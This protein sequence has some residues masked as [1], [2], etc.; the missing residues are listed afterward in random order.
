MFR[1]V[2]M[3]GK[4]QM[5]RQVDVADL[6]Q[7]LVLRVSYMLLIYILMNNALTDNPLVI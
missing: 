1:L 6:V 7:C 3:S 5:C 2:D 4:S